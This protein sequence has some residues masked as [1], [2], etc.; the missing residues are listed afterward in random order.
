VA[1][2]IC[3]HRGSCG[4]SGLAAAER[5]GRAIEMGVD[6]VELDVRRTVDGIRVNYHDDLTP[7]GRSAGSLT[8][9]ELK[10]EAGAELLTLDDL[11]DLVAL[12]VGLHVDLKEPGDGVETL[13]AILARCPDGGFVV[14]T[15]EVESIRAIKAALPTVRVGLTLG[16][17][18]R[19]AR[20]WATLRERWSELFPEERLKRSG[21]DFVAVHQQLARLRLLRYCARK[22]I[23]AWV[24]TV[25][26][27]AEIAHFMADRRV[28][29]VITNRPDIALRLRAEGQA[30]SPH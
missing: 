7:S 8:Y 13:R 1:V 11:L 2:L 16:A 29:T 12:R 22:G 4:V 3:A 25:D 21:A 6:Y 17:D 14:T 26:A 20:T 19:N 5:Y 15:G 28:T 30:G 24:W 9:R 10:A 27:E 18:V 23:A